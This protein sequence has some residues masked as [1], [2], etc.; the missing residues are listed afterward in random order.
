[1]HISADTPWHNLTLAAV[2]QTLETTV[3]GLSVAQVRSRQQV[4]GRNALPR[5]SA[6]SRGQLFFDQINSPL[7]YILLVAAAVSGWLG[8]AVDMATIIAIVLLNAVI[9][10]FQEY[11][12]NRA[13][14]QL[15]QYVQ[16]YARVKRANSQT[17]ILTT[18][19]VL[20]DIIFVEAGMLVPADCRLIEAMDL[21]VV[22]AT[23]TGESSASTKTTRVQPKGAAL[24][25]RENMIYAG[26][27]VAQ[28]RGIGVVCATGIHTAMGQIASLVEATPEEQ[29]PLQNK[30]AALARLL[31]LII[32]LIAV[33]LFLVGV[34][35]GH[36]IEEMLIIS[37]AVAVAAIP[38]GLVVALT[39][40]L[41]L[42]MRKILKHQALVRRLVAAETLGST[43][44]ICTDKTGT[45][46]VGS[47]RVTALLTANS[48]VG[49]AD[50]QSP[51]AAA[52][53]ILALRIGALCNDAAITTS[54]DP[55]KELRLIGDPVDQA[56]LL[57]AKAVGLE[58]S[59][60]ADAT[61]RLQE[62]SFTSES[63]YMATVHRG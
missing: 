51:A 38:E 61:P 1:M 3:A 11:K 36:S 17:Q 57:A 50:D 32:G 37:V 15:Q 2:Y 48:R 18:E 24:A 27:T 9:G 21:S 53:A 39:I 16:R 52:D 55:L 56:L 7:V 43:T 47:L 8:H 12:T 58:S 45:L 42:G 25:E 23:L 22:E 31:G 46:T 41:V 40:I 29:T 33:G 26:T 28:G 34:S 44:V 13:L 35:A 6:T 14:E 63:R 10:F 60:L 59:S 19:L 20:G 49:F 4:F 62:L 30:I 54:D 5:R